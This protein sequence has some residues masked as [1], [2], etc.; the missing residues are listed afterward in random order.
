MR[1]W[2]NLELLISGCDRRDL[3]AGRNRL[4]VAVADL[5][6]GEFCAGRFRHSAGLCDHRAARGR[7][8]AAAGD[9]GR[10]TDRDAR[11][12]GAVK[13]LVVDPMLRH[14][15]LPLGIA[16]IALGVALQESTKAAFG[17]QAFP[18]PGVSGGSISGRCSSIGRTCWCS[19]PR[20]RRSWRCTC[21]WHGR[22]PGGACRRRRRTRR[23]LHPRDFR[24]RMILLTFLSTRPS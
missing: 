7:A 14:G 17:A 22:A 11:A 13:L 23:S 18:F 9:A 24:R 10:A 15:V 12:G 5:I 19:P 6:D 21:S 20:W 2:D 3:R 8:A 4:Y 16:A 1:S